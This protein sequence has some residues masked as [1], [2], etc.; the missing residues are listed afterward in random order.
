MWNKWKCNRQ[1]TGMWYK[2]D[3]V[4]ERVSSFVLAEIARKISGNGCVH[5]V[6]CTARMN[7]QIIIKQSKQL[8][9]VTFNDCSN[10]RHPHTHTHARYAH[11]PTNKTCVCSS[12]W[13]W[14]KHQTLMSETDEMVWTNIWLERKLNTICAFIGHT[15]DITRCCVLCLWWKISGSQM[16]SKTIFAQI[17]LS[18]STPLHTALNRFTL[19]IYCAKYSISRMYDGMYPVS[20]DHHHSMESTVWWV[21]LIF[22]A[23]QRTNRFGFSCTIYSIVYCLRST[24]NF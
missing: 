17:A 5:D 11:W 3:C 10:C 7:T 4:N 1:R 22:V 19:D 2:C 13:D 6:L 18:L 21:E 15:I 9:T 12:Q 8:S 23:V 24:L 20:V 14:R 16:I